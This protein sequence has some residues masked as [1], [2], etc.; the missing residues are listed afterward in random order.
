MLN[1]KLIQQPQNVDSAAAVASP[2]ITANAQIMTHQAALTCLFTFNLGIYEI[3][4]FFKPRVYF[5]TSSFAS[6]R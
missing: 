4:S 5:I 6:N 1:L 3:P 2:Y